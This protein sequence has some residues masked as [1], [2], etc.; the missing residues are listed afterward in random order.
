MQLGTTV[1]SI[2]IISPVSA[3]STARPPSAEARWAS[4][5]PPMQSPTAQIFGFAVRRYSSTTTWRAVVDLDAELLEAD[6]GR[7]RAAA[8][9]HEQ[10]L[11]RDL[12]AVVELHRDAVVAVLA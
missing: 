6:A 12:G 5:S 4:W 1:R 10:L 8:H 3:F 7:L 9:R 2:G 11:G